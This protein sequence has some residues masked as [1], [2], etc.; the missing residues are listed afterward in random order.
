MR[1]RLFLSLWGRTWF[2]ALRV[3]RPV[4]AARRESRPA[5]AGS[6]SRRAA[7]SAAIEISRL[8]RKEDSESMRQSR[9]YDFHKAKVEFFS[10]LRNGLKTHIRPRRNGEGRKNCRKDTCCS[11]VCIP[12]CAYRFVSEVAAFAAVAADLSTDHDFLQTILFTT[13]T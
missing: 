4:S 3:M 6:R 11:C 9:M 13:P 7:F 12:A 1:Q 2:D 5:A 10:R 8:R